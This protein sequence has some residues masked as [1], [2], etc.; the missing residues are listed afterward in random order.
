LADWN[1]LA[2]SASSTNAAVAKDLLL[3]SPRRLIKEKRGLPCIIHSHIFF[4]QKMTFFPMWTVVTLI[5][6]LL[7]QPFL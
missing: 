5:P 6:Y 2:L 4:N 3:N 7:L 1:K